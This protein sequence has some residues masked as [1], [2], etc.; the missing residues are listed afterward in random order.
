MAKQVTWNVVRYEPAADRETVVRKFKIT[1]LP[2][3][4]DAARLGSTV[5]HTS[6]Y[7]VR[8]ASWLLVSYKCGARIFA[9]SF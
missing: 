4:R 3:A 7:E 1:E 8:R 9:T 6:Y 5:D 2:Q